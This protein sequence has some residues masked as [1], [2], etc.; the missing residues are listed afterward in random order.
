MLAAN[1][2]AW[3]ALYIAAVTAKAKP[4]EKWRDQQIVNILAEETFKKCAYCESVISHVSYPHVEHIRPKSAR[5]DLVLE[6]TNLTLSCPK[7]NITKGDYYDE[8]A[9][10][11]HPYE[12]KV[13]EHITFRGPMVVARPGSDIGIRSLT[14]L[15]L[16]RP[17]LF[18]ERAKRIEALHW[19]LDQWERTTGSDKAVYEDLL[20]SAL[21][22]DREF[23]ACLREYALS[24]GF[25]VSKTE[26]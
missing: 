15:G 23:V 11:A 7:C 3:T 26:S 19:L 22:D 1:A 12:H 5:P 17:E 21:G 6:W 2:E 4:P 16:K 25:D 10:L 13:E 20:R 8:T 14:R 24:L 18:A 9:P